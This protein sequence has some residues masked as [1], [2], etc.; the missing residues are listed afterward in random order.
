MVGT[1][2]KDSYCSPSSRLFSINMKQKSSVGWRFCFDRFTR[3]DSLEVR[4][5][6]QVYLSMFCER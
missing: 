3:T 5:K 6:L 1:L 2:G 4:L